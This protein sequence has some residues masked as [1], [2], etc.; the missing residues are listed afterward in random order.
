M[1]ILKKKVNKDFIYKYRYIIGGVLAL[2]LAGFV[3]YKT[4]PTK[5]EEPIKDETTNENKEKK[6]NIRKIFLKK[7]NMFYGKVVWV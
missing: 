2:A 3:I 5:K 6:S 7:K 4:R 1:L